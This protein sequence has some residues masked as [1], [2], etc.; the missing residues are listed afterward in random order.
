MTLQKI[1]IA[2][3][4]KFRKKRGISQMTLADLCDTSGNYIGEIEMGRRIPSFE[5][6]E[7]IASALKIYAYQLLIEETQEEQKK[8]EQKARAFLEN[9]PDRA[10]KEITSNL[11]GTITNAIDKSLDPKNY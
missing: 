11:L 4:K 6:I 1:F 7:R 5:K 3:L 9:L 10:K 2:N 8:K